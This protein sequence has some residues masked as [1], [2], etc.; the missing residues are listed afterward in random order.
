MKKRRRLQDCV[1]VLDLV[2]KYSNDVANIRNS[3]LEE[4]R[5]LGVYFDGKSLPTYQEERN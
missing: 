4:W 1:E 5:F 2:L 3:W